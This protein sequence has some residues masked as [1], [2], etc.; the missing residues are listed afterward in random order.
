[1]ERVSDKGTVYDLN[2]YPR[3]LAALRSGKPIISKVSDP[4]IDLIARTQLQAH[5]SKCSLRVPMM[6]AGQAKGYVVIWDSRKE[7]EW[8]SEEIQLSQTLA[9][10]S[11]MAIE[12][13]R[14]FDEVQRLAVTDQLTGLYN[15][16]GLFDYGQREIDRAHRYQRHLAAILLDID[17]FKQINDTFS[18]AIGDQVLRILSTRC[19]SGLR[20]MDILARYGGEEFAILLPETDLESAHR[21]AERLREQIAETPF[22]TDRGPISI[23]ISIGITSTQFD[24]PDIAVLLDRA[25]T[26]MYAA[27]QAG[28]NRV[29]IENPPK[30]ITTSRLQKKKTGSLYF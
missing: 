27:K 22:Q 7:R 29:S 17:R 18:H 21:V 13:A 14:L 6:V 9:N 11:G 3:M 5:Q 12:N 26:A 20:D 2:E 16:R 1:M 15:R 28:R 23:T 4:K 8:T 24:T 30:K 19:Q 25:D 10:L